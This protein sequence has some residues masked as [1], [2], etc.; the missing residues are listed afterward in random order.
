MKRLIDERYPIYATADLSIESKEG[1]HDAVV[2]EIV[3]ALAIKLKCS[4]TET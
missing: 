4:G 3:H 1:P 2:D